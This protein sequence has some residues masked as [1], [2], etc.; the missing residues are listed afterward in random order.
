MRRRSRCRRRSGCRCASRHRSR[1]R[2]RCRLVG[3]RLWRRRLLRRRSLRLRLS[4]CRLSLRSSFAWSLR[5]RR[6]R[7]HLLG[8]IVLATVLRV[9]LRFSARLN[10]AFDFLLILNEL[11]IRDLYSWWRRNQEEECKNQACDHDGHVEEIG[12]ARGFRHIHDR[13]GVDMFTVHPCSVVIG[14]AHR[15]RDERDE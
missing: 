9:L 15:I 11:D 14:V 7:C 4:W 13:I 10:L 6:R 1:C 12:A 8:R 2:T 5:S 3:C